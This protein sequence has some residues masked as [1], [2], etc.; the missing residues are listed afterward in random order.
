[1]TPLTARTGLLL[2]AGLFLLWASLPL[3][4]APNISLD[5][6]EGLIWGRHWR[7]GYEKH[8]PLQAWLLEGARLLLG[9]GPAAHIWLSSLCAAVCTLAVWKTASMVVDQRTALWS[10]L[11]LQTVYF[12]N[13]AIPEFNPNVLQL[14]FFAAAGLFAVRALKSGRAIDWLSL[15]ATLGAGMYAKYSVALIAV[16]I[17]LFFI[18]DRDGRRRLMSVWPYAGALLSGLIFL[19][20]LAFVLSADTGSVGYVLDRAQIA[21]D[22]TGRMVNVAEFAAN[23][24]LVGAPLLLAMGLARPARPDTPARAGDPEAR[25]ILWLA[26][27]PL[28]LTALM[29]LLAGFRIKSAWIAPLWSFAP[30]ALILLWRIRADA[31]EF[32]R[33]AA[34]ILFMTALA[35]AAYA[36]VNLI[37][38]YV[39]DKP[40]R[41]HFPGRALAAEMDRLWSASFDR[42]LRVVIGP[43]LEAGSAAHYSAFSPAVR[44]NDDE[45][46]S[47]WA[48][49]ALVGKVGAAVIWD[50]SR[51][52]DD[53]PAD[54]RGRWPTAYVLD[55]VE[56]P[57]QTGAAVPPARLGIAAIPP[58][59]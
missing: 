35:P 42:P 28:A 5:A 10:A 43:T 47:P 56:L 51:S 25:L 21:D 8:P 45:A 33:A 31:P 40:M 30:L 34:G 24:L 52:G 14:P 53:I 49:A 38:P 23:L 48:S 4:V 50:A 16:S 41:I 27:A 36:G 1:V 29:G 39:A 20:H 58:A 46:A 3:L 17:A 37:R 55:I 7:L 59:P 13:Y 19:P 12:H 22:F 57:H 54:I 6:A 9:T 32:R 15:G 11:A 2:I 44:V 26:L 18:V